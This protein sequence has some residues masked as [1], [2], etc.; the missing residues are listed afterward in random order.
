[1]QRDQKNSAMMKNGSRFYDRLIT[2]SVFP[3]QLFRCLIVIGHL[4]GTN[5]DMSTLKLIMAQVGLSGNTRGARMDTKEE[6]G[7]A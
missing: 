5:A 4:I 6:Y 2:S 1:M 7:G 3:R